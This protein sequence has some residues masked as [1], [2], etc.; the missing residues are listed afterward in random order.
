MNNIIR[1]IISS[2]VEERLISKKNN[3]ALIGKTGTG[4][5]ILADKI[6]K[7]LDINY[8]R[9]SYF[10]DAWLREEDAEI[11]A[12]FSTI[13]IDNFI[14]IREISDSDEKEVIILDEISSLNV[15]HKFQAFIENALDN[16]NKFVILISQNWSEYF[17]YCQ[18]HIITGIYESQLAEIPLD[19]P[20][21]WAQKEYLVY[22]RER[23][24]KKIRIDLDEIEE[25]ILSELVPSKLFLVKNF[26]RFYL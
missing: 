20:C 13:N 7:S 3:I 15:I 11:K 19:I 2:I 16:P 9:I 8:Y 6:A 5:S 12:A 14:R 1:N 10:F 17:K 24:Y 4:K 26:R 22:F 18:N 23:L 25:F 21:D